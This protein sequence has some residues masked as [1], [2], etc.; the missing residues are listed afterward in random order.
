MEQ[1]VDKS[2]V[3]LQEIDKKTAKRMIEKNHYSHKF[4]SCR[5]AIGIFYK[6][7]KPH[8]FFSDMNEEELDK[9]IRATYFPGK[10]APFIELFGHR[11]EYNPK[12]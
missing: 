12:R 3:Y 5:Y 2:R 8:P 7:D 10:P 6:S 4:S 1:Y 9:R 11:F